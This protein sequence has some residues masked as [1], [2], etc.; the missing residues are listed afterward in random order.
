MGARLFGKATAQPA[1]AAFIRSFVYSRRACYA[2]RTVLG[3]GSGGQ[4]E[5][6]RKHPSS[7]GANI[8]VWREAVN[9]RTDE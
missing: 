3:A 7:K 9:M 8:P 1:A 4:G 6:E 5:G 2:P